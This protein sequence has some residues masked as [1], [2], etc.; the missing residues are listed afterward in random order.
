MLA[1][2]KDIE[3]LG[4]VRGFG[5]EDGWF[6]VPRTIGLGEF[7]AEGVNTFMLDVN[8]PD[9]TEIVCGI[10]EVT[11]SPTVLSAKM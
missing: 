3:V 2:A 7:A 8:V 10:R 9:K 5:A 11:F 1:S 6:D 4:G